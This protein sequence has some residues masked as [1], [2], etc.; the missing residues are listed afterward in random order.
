MLAAAVF[1]VGAI[2]RPSPVQAQTCVA[3]PTG[4]VA[5]WA[6]D[7]NAADRA[8]NAEG[9]LA[10]LEEGLDVGQVQT[11]DAGGRGGVQ[12]AFGGAS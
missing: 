1:T 6:G 2:L 11:L 3:P 9:D 5:W 8:H 4:I 7:G 10:F 12:A